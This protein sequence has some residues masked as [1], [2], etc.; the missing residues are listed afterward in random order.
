MS[1]TMK[2]A[3]RGFKKKRGVRTRMHIGHVELSG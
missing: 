3:A 2:W 1:I